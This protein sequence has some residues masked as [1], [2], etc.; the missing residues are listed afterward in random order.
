MAQPLR[1][2]HVMCVAL[3]KCAQRVMCAGLDN[4]VSIFD[5]SDD[6]RVGPYA[7]DS[8]PITELQFHEGYI[9][10]LDFMGGM[11]KVLSASGDATVIME[12][13][14]TGT[15]KHLRRTHG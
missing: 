13:E 9:A 10:S 2:S 14:K 12:C 6:H 7:W 4:L 1:S 15:D 8:T 3:S 5:C 11:D